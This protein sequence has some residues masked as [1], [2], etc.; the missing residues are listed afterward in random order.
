[1]SKEVTIEVEADNPVARAV[2]DSENESVTL[3]VGGERYRVTREEP[4][5]LD[6]DELRAHLRRFSGFLTDAEAEKMKED[7]YRAREEGSQHN[8]P[9]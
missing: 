5:K 8:F 7:I 9:D 6:V 4:V 1:M 2:H 3:I